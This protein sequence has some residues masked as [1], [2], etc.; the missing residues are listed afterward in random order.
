MEFS[1]FKT[2][3]TINEAIVSVRVSS[4][5]ISGKE[6]NLK[7]KNKAE[8]LFFKDLI[9]NELEHFNERQKE[10][11]L[12]EYCKLLKDQKEFNAKNAAYVWYQLL[13]IGAWMS[14]LKCVRGFMSQK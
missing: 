1:D 3:F 4:E 14:F 8:K 7:L 10:G 13:K 11:L 6:D 12:L 5:S 2:I 9:Y